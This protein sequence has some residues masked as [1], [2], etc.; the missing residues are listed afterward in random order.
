MPSGCRLSVQ[1]KEDVLGQHA[2]PHSQVPDTTDETSSD[3]QKQ[4]CWPVPDIG[5]L[6]LQSTRKY[7]MQTTFECIYNL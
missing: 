4:P 6:S 2:R 3:P 7:E 5:L 1:H